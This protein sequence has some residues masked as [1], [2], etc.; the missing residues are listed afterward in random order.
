MAGVRL[1]VKR[2][3]RAAEASG[4]AMAA[5]PRSPGPGSSPGT[6]LSRCSRSPVPLPD[7]LY[8]VIGGYG[9]R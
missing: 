4:A 7:K 6:S 9:A 1:N 2:V 8:I 5:A 3:E